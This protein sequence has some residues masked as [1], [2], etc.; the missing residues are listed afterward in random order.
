M[1]AKD[2]TRQADYKYTTFK[3]IHCGEAF[4]YENHLYIKA[5]GISN[6]NAVRLDNGVFSRF[7]DD[8]LV[9]HLKSC[10]IEYELWY[11]NEVEDEKCCEVEE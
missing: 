3:Y 1:I 5:L 6:T 8:D 10:K 2:V 11:L 4:L 7:N 9:H